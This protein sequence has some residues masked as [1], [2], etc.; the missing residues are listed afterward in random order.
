MLRGMMA[1]VASAFALTGVAYAQSAQSN[2]AQVTPEPGAASADANLSD[3]TVYE[4]AFYTRFHPQNALDMVNQ[5][6]N[7]ALNAGDNRRGFSG[8]V[9]NLLIDGRRPVAKSQTVQTI[10]QQIPAAQV[11]RIELLRGAAVAGDASGL[12]VLV[13]VVRVA[14]AG[15]GVYN[16]A[17]EWAG[18]RLSPEPTAS[19]SGR[20]GEVDYSLG[21]SLFDQFRPLPGYRLLFD[22]NHNLT[23]HVQTPSPRSY[24]EETLN[25]ALAF[26]LLGGRLSTTEQLD[27]YL[28]KQRN[29]FVTFD[30]SNVEQEDLNDTYTEQQW[31]LEIGA[32]YDRQVGPWTL[33]MVG[34]IN[35]RYFDNREI[36]A[37]FDGLGD[38]NYLVHQADHRNSGESIL[39]ASIAR[40]VGAHHFEFGAEGAINTLDAKLD[41]TQDTG[42]GP[43]DLFIPNANV[44]VEEKRDE[45]FIDYTWRPDAKWSLEAR[46][47]RE[48][49]T[50]TFTGDADQSVHLAFWKPSIQISRSFLGADQ[51]RVRFYRDVGQLNFDDFVSATSVADN[52]ISGGNPNLRPQTEYRLELGGDL[53]LPLGAALTFAFTH[54]WIKDTADE[55][56]V[57]A[58]NPPNPPIRFDAPGNIGPASADSI[59]MHFTMPFSPIL[60]GAKVTFDGTFYN[61]RVKDPIT[62]RMRSI[63]AQ[64]EENMTGE[65]RQDLNNLKFAWGFEYQ[66][67]SSLEYWRHDE[68]DSQR[69]GPYLDFFVESTFI[70]GLKL[71]ATAENILRSPIL[72]ERDFFTPDR[73][74][75]PLRSEH[76]ER[77]FQDAPLILLSVSGS[78]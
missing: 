4:A 55:I 53:A 52:L 7:F 2:E 31:S 26:P 41:I 35:R 16:L 73:A 56:E 65:F 27:A 44:S 34:L 70:P 43:V 62:G 6:P 51:L 23:G 67:V 21:A 1:S 24:G 25:G 20:N 33:A 40:D 8:A 32:N 13:N 46:L 49:S 19:W 77:S 28:V 12:S 64:P 78:F 74:G 47:A 69:D 76:R 63:S 50:L 72:R 18:H 14:S 71:K 3:R 39:R 10:L 42:S 75:V 5:T 30:N 48:G 11:V 66:K 60:P 15:S 38:F 54:H 29:G 9:G 59:T 58:P 45:T 36:D 61:S 37:D 57:I 68:T 17:A 22:A